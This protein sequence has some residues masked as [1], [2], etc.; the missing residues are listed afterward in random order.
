VSLQPSRPP[1]SEVVLNPRHTDASDASGDATS[2]DPYEP[3]TGEWH[4]RVTLRDGTHVLLRPIRREDRQR[5]VEGMK[6]LSPASRYLRFHSSVSELSEDQLDYL[7][8]VD[9]VDHEAIVALDLDHPDRPGVGVARYIREPFEPHVAEAAITVADEYHG[10]GAGTLLLGALAARAREN[11]ITVFRNYVLDGNR[12]MLEVFDHLGA[13]R[14]LET[15]GLWRV[16]LDVPADDE[17]MPSSGA[18]RAFM[19]IAREQHTLASLIPPIWSRWRRRRHGPEHDEQA[20]DGR[21]ARDRH[22]GEHD[23]SRPDDD[24]DH[25]RGRFPDLLAEELGQLREDLDHWLEDP[26]HR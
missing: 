5:L 18:G 14:E 11:D 15:D 3:A 10:Q 13:H 7:S 19:E 20:D 24:E 23:G 12:A 16:D 4:R 8:D 26:K 6:R 1:A 22:G 21:G 17:D 25:W 9:H 2:P